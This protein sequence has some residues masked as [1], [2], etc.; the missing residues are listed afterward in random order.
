[1]IKIT[2]FFVLNEFNHRIEIRGLIKR[3]K[4]KNF[5]IFFKKYYSMMK[6]IKKL[7]SDIWGKIPT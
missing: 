2:Y 3:Q 5:S 6:L 7:N 1:M 4:V